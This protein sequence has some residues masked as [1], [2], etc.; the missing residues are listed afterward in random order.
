M[1]TK[2]KMKM[3]MKTMNLKNLLLKQMMSSRQ[4]LRKNMPN[5][6]TS[7]WKKLQP[8]RQKQ[9]LKLQLLRI[10]LLHQRDS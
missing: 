7:T 9:L 10:L 6:Q 5:V 4:R 3:K 2:L 1:K 8:I